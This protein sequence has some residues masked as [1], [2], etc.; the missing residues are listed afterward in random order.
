MHE[1][2][3][4][5]CGGN[6]IYMSQIEFNRVS[7]HCPTFTKLFIEHIRYFGKGKFFGGRNF[8]VRIK[9]GNTNGI[10]KSQS[11]QLSR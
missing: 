3:P 4:R 7:K 11:S 5:P 9:I 8:G 6:S 2:L 1:T 10:R